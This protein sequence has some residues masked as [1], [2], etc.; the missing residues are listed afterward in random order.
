MGTMQHR[1]HNEGRSRATWT[2]PTQGKF[3]LNVDASVFSGQ[4]SFSMGMILRDHDGTF[5][6]ARKV[7][8]AGEI[9]V[10]EA[11]AWGVLEAL[12]WLQTLPVDHVEIESDSLLVVNALK[13]KVEYCLE[14]DFVLRDCI[15][16]LQSRPDV[17]I[18]FA[19]KHANKTAH[20]LA[21]VSCMVNNFIDFLSPL[22]IVLETLVVDSIKL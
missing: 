5:I 18:S 8:R 17:S 20:V 13:K 19:K 2:A 1:R 11:E 10:L 9:P 16:I 14:V 12:K 21:R 22:L 15:S 4:S 3:K 6:K 7:K